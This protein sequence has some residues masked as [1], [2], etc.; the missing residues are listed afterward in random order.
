M[1]HWL[2]C[3]DASSLVLRPG[4]TQPGHS[5]LH[6]HQQADKIAEQLLP[7]CRWTLPFKPQGV[8][9]WTWLWLDEDLRVME[10]SKGSMFIHR[11]IP[12]GSIKP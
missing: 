1:S 10:G 4:G 12:D 2:P 3:A 8:G 7:L 6:E 11:R 9:Y 5:R